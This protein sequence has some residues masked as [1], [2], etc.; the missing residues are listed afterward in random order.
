VSDIG[1][2]LEFASSILRLEVHFDNFTRRLLSA[3]SC[4]ISYILS[5]FTTNERTKPGNGWIRAPDL[6][7]EDGLLDTFESF[8]D[9]RSVWTWSLAIEKQCALREKGTTRGYSLNS[10]TA[11]LRAACNLLAFVNYCIDTLLCGCREECLDRA[12]THM[13]VP[14]TLLL[15]MQPFSRKRPD[16]NILG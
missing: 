7:D 16:V 4:V 11:T 13:Y 10:R 9:A 6:L 8:P 15:R 12:N 14:T 3:S 2:I 1:R 5:A